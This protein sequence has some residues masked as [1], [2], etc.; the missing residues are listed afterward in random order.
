MATASRQ[1]GHKPWRLCKQETL[2]SFEDWKAILEFW[3]KQDATFKPFLKK[4]SVWKK[5]KADVNRGLVAK[6]D[7]SAAERAEDLEQMLG[8]VA[9]YCPVIKR[10]TIIF[11]CKCMDDVW[12][13][14]R[15]H[16]GFHTSGATFLD[17]TSVR[18]ESDE[19]PE[20]LYQRMAAFIGDNLLKKDSELTHDGEKTTADELLSPTLENLTVLLWLERVHPKLP[21]I[22][23]QKYAA[24]LRTTKTL[25][26]L[27]TEISMSIPSLLEEAQVSEEAKVMRAKGF[28]FRKQADTGSYSR[29]QIDF[30]VSRPGDHVMPPDEHLSVLYASRPAEMIYLIG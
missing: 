23:K 30:H 21:A 13:S 14:I 8:Y 1:H 4:D 2:T 28:G 16:Y 5:K 25:F 17:S 22:V 27:K 3:L 24:E 6:D 29:Q 26:S 19:R 11:D 10:N 9:S 18:L 15:L 7:K 12:Q 20:D